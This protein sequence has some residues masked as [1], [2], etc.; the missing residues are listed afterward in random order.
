MSIFLFLF[1]FFNCD[2][3]KSKYHDHAL[4][5]VPTMFIVWEKVLL[6]LVTLKLGISK[7][8]DA[9][10]QRNNGWT[11]TYHSSVSMTKKW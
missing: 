6:E 1:L 9:D 7:M 11:E 10:A 8:S 3:G 2:D 5:H 4:V